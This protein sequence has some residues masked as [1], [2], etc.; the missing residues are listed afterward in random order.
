MKPAGWIAAAGVLFGV[1]CSQPG[2]LV[3]GVEWV[4]DGVELRASS[5]VSIVRIETVDGELL[6]VNALA[7]PASEVFVGVVEPRGDVVVHV[8]GW[9]GDEEQ[10]VS[11]TVAVP[12]PGAWTAEVQPAPGAEWAPAAGRMEVPLWGPSATIFVRLTAGAAAVDVPTGLG[13]VHLPAPGSRALLAVPVTGDRVLHI[14]D[15]ELTLVAV[16]RDVSGAGA[17]LTLDPLVF[18]AEQNGTRDLGRPTDA[19]ALPSPVWE[20]VLAQTGSGVRGRAVEEPWSFVAVPVRNEGP[21]PIDLVVATWVTDGAEPAATFRPRLRS[22]DGGTGRT[23]A[24]LRVPAGGE[25]RAVLPVFVDTIGV[26]SGVYDLHAE[27]TPLGSP[28]VLAS[29]VLPLAVRRGD[30]VSSGGFVATLILSVAG[31]AW[32]A[33]TLPGWLR[34]A[35]TTDLMVNALFG[36]ALFVVSTATD[37]VSMSAGAVLGPFATLFTGILYDAGRTVLIATLLQLQPRPGALALSVLCGWMGRGV[38]TGAISAPDLLY[39]GVAI[40]L[41]EG[42]AWISGLTRGQPLTVLRL[43]I[44]LGLSNA[45]L[46]L[47]G[48]W[49]HTVMYRLTFASWYIALQVGLPGFL[50]V[51]LA[52]RLA[53]PFAESLREV[54]A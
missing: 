41:G 17:A 2:P 9:V 21:V 26:E 18:P 37:V 39:T 30:A 51:L 29:T 46:T 31:L 15:L 38:L 35:S 24:L 42:F 52:C 45:L 54:D 27:V 28:T 8:V 5:P 12:E 23:T 10:R 49:L 3:V 1:G 47:C 36:T 43:S 53:V 20:R 14:G 50:Y 7:T 11:V 32:T 16:H 34:R 22:A 25:S 19:V 6:V 4:G 33:W 48:L 44:A 40:A 13:A